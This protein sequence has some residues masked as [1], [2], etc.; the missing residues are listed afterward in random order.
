MHYA[1]RYA[2]PAGV[3]ATASRRSGRSAVGIA[4]LAGRS[5]CEMYSGLSATASDQALQALQGR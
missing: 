3:T 1:V 5:V 4:F 2:A